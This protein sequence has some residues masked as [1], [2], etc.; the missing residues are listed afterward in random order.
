LKGGRGEAELNST[1]GNVLRYGVVLSSVVL[2][3]GVVLMLSAPPGGAPVS[4][5][6]MFASN[7]GK[8]TLSPSQLFGGIAG[9]NSVSILELGTLI[10][11]ATPLARV[12]TSVLLFLKEKDSLYVGI[13]LLVLAMLLFA[14]F[15]IG[16]LEA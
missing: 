13:T 5:E 3:T 15:V 10:L 14:I 4:L 2:I 12:I 11:L 16:P 6:G 9:G 1:I 8:P 7:F